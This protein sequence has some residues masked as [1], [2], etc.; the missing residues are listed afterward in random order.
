[1]K[2][3]RLYNKGFD[4]L[5]F[6]EIGRQ[7]ESIHQDDAD[8]DRRSLQKDIDIRNCTHWQNASGG[9]GEL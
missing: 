2:I 6:N 3:T 5:L 8:V 7:E 4:V 1:M 9:E